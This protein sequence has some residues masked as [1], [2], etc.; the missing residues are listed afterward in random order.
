MTAKKQNPLLE[1]LMSKNRLPSIEPAPEL[2]PAKVFDTTTPA[3]PPQIARRFG[4]GDLPR[5]GNA[6]F[7][8]LQKIFPHINDRMYGGWLRNIID[9]NA[10]LFIC[11]DGAVLLA[12]RWNE[13]MNPRPYVQVVFWCGSKGLEFPLYEE[14]IRWTTNMGAG[15][16]RL[17]G[18]EDDELIKQLAPRVKGLEDRTTTILHMDDLA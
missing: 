7:P 17:S 16:I 14:V 2:A 3:A 18:F 11:V 10:S 12:Q 4:L 9:D 8:I 1:V 5:Y 6:I 13:P 15:E